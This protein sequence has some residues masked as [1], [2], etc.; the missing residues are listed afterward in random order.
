LRKSFI[1]KICRRFGFEVHGT[2]YMQAL[3]KSTFQEDAF[4]KQTEFIKSANIIFDIGAN[5]G[6]ISLQYNSLFPSAI[7]H[8]FEPFPDMYKTLCENTGQLHNIS[9]HQ[10]AVG[11]KKGKSIFF[12]NHNV[13]TNSLLEPQKIGLSSD[14]Q[15]VNKDKIEVDV[16]SIDEFCEANSVNQIDILKLDIQG[17]ELAALEGAKKMLGAKNIKLIY[18]EA[19]FRKQYVGQP[20]FH[21]ISSYLEQYGYFVQDIYNPIYGKGSIAWCDAVFLPL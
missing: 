2:G 3:Q 11:E 15:V 18:T 7:I 12:V 8:A 5:S 21:D 10:V 4:N 20:L 6:Q 14:K 17:G 1:N 16:I 19:Y 13:D 9:A